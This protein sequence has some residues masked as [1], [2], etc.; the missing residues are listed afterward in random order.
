MT[1]KEVPENIVH[2]IKQRKAIA[3]ILKVSLNANLRQS[4]NQISS[5]I[6]KNSEFKEK[7]LGWI[8][9]KKRYS[10]SGSQTVLEGNK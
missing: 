4:I 1:G 5:E 6:K 3:K 7:N 9:G 2:L 10:P 8:F